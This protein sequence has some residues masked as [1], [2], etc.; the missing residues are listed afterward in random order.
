MAYP[1]STDNLAQF[2]DRYIDPGTGGLTPGTSLNAN[3]FNALVDEI[4]AITTELG[5]MPKGAY[6]DVDARLDA[7]EAGA[8][9]IPK[10]DPA[11]AGNIPIL[12]ADGELEE[13]IM[14][15]TGTTAINLLSSDAVT[16]TAT[17]ILVLQHDSSSTPAAGFGSSILWRLDS[18][19]QEDRDAAEMTVSWTTATDATRTSKVE[20]FNV[21]N[22][23]L[24]GWF[25]SPYDPS[26]LFAGYRVGNRTL[27]GTGNQGKF[28]VMFGG[29]CG[30]VLT[31]GYGNT[32]LGWRAGRLISS[33]SGNTAFGSECMYGVSTSNYN[34]AYGYQ[35][36]K[37]AVGT[38][39]MVLGAFAVDHAVSVNECVCIGYESGSSL[40]AVALNNGCVFIGNQSGFYETQQAK[41]FID[42]VKRSD[43]ADGRIK[44]LIYGIFASTNAAQYLTVNGNFIN[45]IES[46]DTNAVR[47]IATLRH[48]T[49]GVVA[50]GLGTGLA[51][52]IETSTTENT[53]A[54]R[55]SSAWV[56]S[57]HATRKANMILSVYDTAIRTGL[58]IAAT[59][60]GAALTAD[61]TLTVG[62]DDTGYD[63]TFYGA[64]SGKKLL[65]DESADT[66]QVDGA[67]DLN[68][69]ATLG[70]ADTD[71]LTC[72]GRLI[73]RT[74]ADG[75]M[76]ATAGT[77]AE[78]VFNSADSK[79]YGCTVSGSPATWAALN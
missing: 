77:V 69:G 20:I 61:G 58:T 65:W 76:D 75:D 74:V 45:Q 42:N 6:A 78:V 49:T 2:V 9:G 16:T 41:L 48:N 7:L 29:E 72:V 25:H 50:N 79:F 47:T 3:T 24:T 11:T 36:F 63:V 60:S 51:F 10:I 15:Q 17:D 14:S 70:G 71:L 64:T 37:Q 53:D 34:S 33:G 21:Y 4:N 73:V 1:T 55:I 57:T 56:D 23:T 8:G 59:G 22:G 30:S 52:Q 32:T 12:T 38:R 46:T 13:G 39:N 43:E 27:G 68:G 18:D 26:N 5:A 28:N 31:T 40:G 19:T 35:A 62:A 66:L 54:A 44:A 67:F